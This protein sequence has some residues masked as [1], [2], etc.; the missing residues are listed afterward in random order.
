MTRTFL[1][2]LGAVSAYT[3]WLLMQGQASP[4]RKLVPA[5][6]AAALLEQAWADHHTRA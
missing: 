6:Q 4:V 2:L 1:L 5:R 3:A